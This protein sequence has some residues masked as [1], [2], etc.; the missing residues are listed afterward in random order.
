MRIILFLATFSYSFN[1]YTQDL[2][3]TPYKLVNVIYKSTPEAELSL[4]V[5]YPEDYTAGKLPAVVFFFGG[6]WVGGS[7]AHFAPQSKYLASR[8]MIVIT[9]DYRI[10]NEHGTTPQQAVMDARSAMRYVKLHAG[11]L[12]IDTSRLA[13]GGGS[14][15]GHLALSTATLHDFNDPQDDLSL[16]PMPDALLL[17][18]PV[19]N[20]TS[21]GFG[22]KA[23]GSDTLLLSPYH[24]MQINMPPT[25]IFH[26]KADTT[27]PYSNIQAMKA[28]L[29]ALLI[30]N[31]VY[32]YEDLTHGFFNLNREE[33][34]YF[35]ETLYRTDQFLQSLGYLEG[36]PSFVPDSQ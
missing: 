17:F 3:S 15:G 30:P 1:A 32:A 33:G 28:K 35:Y 36:S 22:A 16:S 12:G 24:R 4:D 11:E 31:Q 18:N 19:V 26:G 21:E 14:A 6:G 13:A 27:V 8:G 20:T 25:L 10:E 23:V 2:S 7:R 9:P 29:D 34:R 5:Y